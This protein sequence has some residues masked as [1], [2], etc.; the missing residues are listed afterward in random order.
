MNTATIIQCI[1]HIH[2]GPMKS[3]FLGGGLCFALEKKNYLHVPIVFL[4][5]VEYGGYML[6]KSRVFEKF[7]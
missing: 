1:K 5:P 6:Y 4:L 3:F 2:T 7:F